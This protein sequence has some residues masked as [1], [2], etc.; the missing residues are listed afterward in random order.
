MMRKVWLCFGLTLLALTLNG[1]AA[2]STLF[3][4]QHVVTSRDYEYLKSQQGAPLQMP[5]GVD[6]SQLGNDYPLPSYNYLVT[7]VAVSQ[8]PPGSAAAH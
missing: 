1:C 2:F 5:I 6:G 8:I 7:N 4:K 3:N